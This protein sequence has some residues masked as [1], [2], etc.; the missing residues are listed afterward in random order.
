MS[1]TLACP[2]CN[3]E[4]VM[5]ID[6]DPLDLQTVPFVSEIYGRFV[7]LQAGCHHKFYQW[8]FVSVPEKK[9]EASPLMIVA[10]TEIPRQVIEN[11]F[12][13][14][15]EGG[16][17]YW[18]FLNKDATDDIR[19]AVPKDVDPYLSTAISKAILDHGVEVPVSDVEDEESVLGVISLKTINERLTALAN[20]KR[21]KWAF[22]AE[23]KE[24]GDAESSDVWFQY[25]AMGQVDFS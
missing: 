10:H 11:V 9:Q 4:T 13:T 5:M 12:V 7:C 20:D 2:K 14:A 8:L 22:D 18:Y 19:K 16:S 17:N 6:H 24:E 15:L 23:M 21:Y 3:Q 1:K 25:M